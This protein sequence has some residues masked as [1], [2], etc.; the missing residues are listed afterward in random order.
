ME[1][2]E[3]EQR[4]ELLAFLA[5]PTTKERVERLAAAEELTQSSWLNRTVSA[6]VRDMEVAS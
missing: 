6:V 2:A 3:R 4:T 1:M 5:T